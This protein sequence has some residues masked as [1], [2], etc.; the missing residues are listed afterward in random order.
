MASPFVL[1]DAYVI[2]LRAG[3]APPPSCGCFFLLQAGAPL[4][5]EQQGQPPPWKAD[6][7]S[8]DESARRVLAA[9]WDASDPTR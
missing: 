1:S 2:G 6:L 4:G 7:E 9:N 3:A 8:V 5:G